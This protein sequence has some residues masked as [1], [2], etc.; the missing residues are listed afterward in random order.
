MN[1]HLPQS[2]LSQSLLFRVIAFIGDHQVVSKLIAVFF[3]SHGIDPVIT[4]Q[5]IHPALKFSAG[6]VLLPPAQRLFH[7]GLQQI[8][9]AV[10]VPGQ[11]ITVAS[12]LG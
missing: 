5:A 10:H 1:L 4:A 11:R 7:A 8:I 2:G 9:S 6:L 3:C 12:Q